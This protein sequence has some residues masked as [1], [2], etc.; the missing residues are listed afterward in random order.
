MKILLINPPYR[1]LMRVG[2][3]YFPLGLGYLA[4]ILEKSGYEVKI[5]N[6][7]VPRDEEKNCRK[8]KGGDFS[9]IMSSH[10]RYL[11]NLED[12]DFFV[13]HEFRK[14]LADFCPD[15]VGISARTP[16]F[17]SA[18]EIAKIVK[19][20][21]SDCPIVW[22]GSHP[23]I[24]PE[25]VLSLPEADFLVCGEGERTLL[26][27]VRA[28]EEGKK[29]FLEIRG[30]SYKNQEGKIIK[31]LSR[32]YIHD[33]D[34]LPMPARH[35]IFRE[36]F[37][38]PGTYGDLMASRGCPFFC[39]YCSAQSLWGRK[40][41]YRSIASIIK[42]LKILKNNYQ[43]EIIRFIDDNLT[44]ERTYIEE[45]CHSLIVEKLNIKWGCLSRV[46]LIDEKL[47]KLMTEAGCYRV[48]I[49]VE[50][51][52]PRILEIIKKNINLRDVLRVDK[53][54]NKYDIAWTAFFI[55][56]F[57]YETMDDLKATADF[58]KEIDPYRL[59]LS[60]FTPYPGTEDYER[61]NELGVLPKEIDWGLFDHNSPN[62]FFM[63]Y[64]GREE[65]Q[66]FFNQLSDWVSLRNTHRIRG[67][68]LYYLKHPFSL[69]RKITKFIKKRI[70]L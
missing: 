39:T 7:E 57:P 65:Y 15:L 20:W 11:R 42:E 48:D 5:Y 25:E 26:D 56:G 4:A 18:V 2:S 50:S 58:M 41:R 10:Q 14:S 16:M 69:L 54:F 70:Y 30:L 24:M 29:D 43:C 47:L 46:N 13:W 36:D 68:E 63:K 1:R 33:L 12:K 38:A 3:A 45:L 34:E 62:N 6:G 60:N 59:V 37:Y 31:N 52:S 19:D 64:V 49:G 9:S 28:L 67:K 55:T 61:A 51:G 17:K 40:M 27:L 35:L 32:D 22:G 66:N 21:R 8:H 23:T 53:L 44:L